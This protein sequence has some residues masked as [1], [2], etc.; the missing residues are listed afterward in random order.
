MQ[1]FSNLVSNA[2]GFTPAGGRVSV[3]AVDAGASVLFRVADTGPGIPA[4]ELPW[5]FDRYRK[6]TL[7]QS[8][9]TGLGLAIA[10]GLV[11]AHG[12]EMSVESTL[13]SGTTFSFSLPRAAPE[14][15]VVA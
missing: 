9:G 13:G 7:H 14:G 4:E 11:L 1:V 3:E 15:A 6:S 12:G 10:R 5:I 2:L 8:T